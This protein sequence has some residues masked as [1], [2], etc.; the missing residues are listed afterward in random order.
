[1]G[2][3]LIGIMYAGPVKFSDED[4]SKAAETF[5]HYISSFKAFE[6]SLN[7]IED[8][9]EVS[10]LQEDFFS[11]INV[12][13]D[14]FEERW[15]SFDSAVSLFKTGEDFVSAIQHVWS[16]E[17]RDVY[18]RDFSPTKDASFRVVFAGDSSW[19]D[20]PDGYGYRILKMINHMPDIMDILHIQ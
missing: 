16:G 2:R 7:E 8:P 1:M 3:D 20:E 15:D 13:P 17:S 19:G 12:L 6:A 5:Q 4:F 10:S 11:S 9:E 18:Y 14:D